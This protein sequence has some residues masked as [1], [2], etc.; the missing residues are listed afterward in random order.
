MRHPAHTGA[1]GN[2][3]RKQKMVERGGPAKVI[4][5]VESGGAEA[6][7]V[8]VA[9]RRK[10]RR[11]TPPPPG[12]VR[13]RRRRLGGASTVPLPNS[14]ILRGICPAPAASNKSD[15]IEQV[16]EQARGIRGGGGP[17]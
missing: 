10:A 16:S 15:G 8:A 12:C 5:H 7:A 9:L 6:P 13:H 17:A 1:T 2:T 3:S 4:I 14:E 11:S